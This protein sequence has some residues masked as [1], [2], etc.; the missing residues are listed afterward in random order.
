LSSN[1]FNN[2]RSGKI[3]RW[4]RLI[5]LS[6]I[7]PCV[8][9]FGIFFVNYTDSTTSNNRTIITEARLIKQEDQQF[10][11]KNTYQINNNNYI[12]EVQKIKKATYKI[13]SIINI[14]AKL[15]YWGSEP[16]QNY[17]EIW[18]RGYKGE[19]VIIKSTYSECDIICLIYSIQ[20]NITSIALNVLTSESCNPV[21]KFILQNSIY[22]CKDIGQLAYSFMFGKVISITNVYDL[23]YSYG[24]A[25]LIVIS[26]FQITFLASVIKRL[27]TKLSRKLQLIGTVLI[28]T[29][30]SLVVGLDPP[31]LRALLTLY[32]IEGALWYFG[33]RVSWLRAVCYSGI[34]IALL[35]PRVIYS[36]SF[37]LTIAASIAVG[38]FIELPKTFRIITILLS[39][40]MV[41]LLT[42]VF[43]PRGVRPESIILQVL[44][45]PFVLATTIFSSASIIPFI[46]GF[47]AFLS[48]IFSAVSVVLLS[49]Y[50]DWFGA[51]N[52]III[53]QNLRILWGIVG[54]FCIVCSRLF[55]EIIRKSVDEKQ[56]ETKIIFKPRWW[57][58]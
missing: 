37:E 43:L 52:S 46:G 47:A 50:H 5:N 11:V 23:Y 33:R 40:I 4:S 45:E 6:L 58:W 39:G 31:I 56:K 20:S 32:I 27:C 51:A 44:L 22:N 55:V 41:S 26:G 10:T 34:I 30:Y 2:L 49:Y 17:R 9:I 28:T 38:L 53:D 18:S 42:A 13:G 57:N 7:L 1:I 54:L 35:E 21:S 24:L 3:I 29:I 8:L 12:E 16:P 25:H 36:L 19:V 15:E 48:V 14:T